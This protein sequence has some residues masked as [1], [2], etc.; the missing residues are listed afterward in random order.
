M[1]SLVVVFPAEP[2]IAARRK[3]VALLQCPGQRLQRFGRL[4]R[5]STTGK[6]AGRP[7]G[8]PLA[9]TALRPAGDGVAREVVAVDPRAADRD[10]EVARP[11]RA[12]VDGGAR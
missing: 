7:G 6:P 4:L 5:P 12:R 10:E 1:N 8:R 2:V 3:P 11:R 9:R